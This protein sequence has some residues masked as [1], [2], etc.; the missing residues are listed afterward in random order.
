MTSRRPPV[1]SR[2]SLVA[3]YDSAATETEES[4]VAIIGAKRKR[5]G[6]ESVSLH[7]TDSSGGLNVASPLP[8]LRRSLTYLIIATQKKGDVDRDKEW[9]FH[10][11][12]KGKERTTV[13]TKKRRGM[14]CPVCEN[15][16]GV[17]L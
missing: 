6:E 4:S 16:N 8:F 2:I 10:R 15:F 7:D 11:V 12:E 17:S 1:V 14:Q 3:E 13:W 9:L 5:D